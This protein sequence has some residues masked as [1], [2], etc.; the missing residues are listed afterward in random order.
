M[1][2]FLRVCVAPSAARGKRL[3]RLCVNGWTDAIQA[4]IAR[5]RRAD[6]LAVRLRLARSFAC[7]HASARALRKASVN[8]IVQRLDLLARGL[9]GFK[10]GAAALRAT[11]VRRLAAAASML[12][13]AKKRLLEARWR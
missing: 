3:L 6:A 1:R 12:R 8:R 13:F 10:E 9:A 5:R 7:W 2:C 11:R 4:G